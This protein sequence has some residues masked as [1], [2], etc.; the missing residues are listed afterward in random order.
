MFSIRCSRS[1]KKNKNI[2]PR[3]QAHSS[4][5]SAQRPPCMIVNNIGD[6]AIQVL[7]SSQRPIVIETNCNI[8]LFFTQVHGMFQFGIMHTVHTDC[9]SKDTL[10][11]LWSN[12]QNIQ[13]ETPVCW[14]T[15]C[16]L[17]KLK[18]HHVSHVSAT[19]NRTPH[20]RQKRKP[21]D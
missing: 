20:L 2:S 6:S 7:L 10:G 8:D 18:F 19:D 17:K 15:K 3:E 12:T 5:E 4:R 11:S 14:I 13:R 21:I 16:I 1:S 9:L